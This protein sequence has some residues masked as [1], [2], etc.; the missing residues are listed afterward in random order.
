[1]ELKQQGTSIPS[2]WKVETLILHHLLS[3][4]KKCLK[5]LY[6]IM[7]NHVYNILDMKF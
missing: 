7:M 1:M 5:E 6:G 4:L 3:N 2:R